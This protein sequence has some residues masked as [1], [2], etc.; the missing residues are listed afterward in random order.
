MKSTDI[1]LALSSVGLSA[2]LLHL[3][4]TK[5]GTLIFCLS[6]LRRILPGHVELLTWSSRSFHLPTLRTKTYLHLE[7]QRMLQVQGLGPYG[8][9]YFL[10]LTVLSY[11]LRLLAYADRWPTSALTKP[12]MHLVSNDKMA[13]VAVNLVMLQVLHLSYVVASKIRGAMF[14]YAK[15]I[16][17]LLDT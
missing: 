16:R 17:C 9:S 11:L 5:L 6:L 10:A 8:G 15:H 4:L 1:C 14:V 13:N 12:T 7:G 2:I 3:I